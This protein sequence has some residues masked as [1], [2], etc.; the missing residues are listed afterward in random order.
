MFEKEP[1]EWKCLR[2]LDFDRFDL[3]GMACKIVS[4]KGH[5][6]GLLGVLIPS[7][8]RVLSDDALTPVMCLNFQNHLSEEVQHELQRKGYMNYKSH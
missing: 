6:G 8:K 1:K 2:Q 3:G 7:L 4:L 5:T